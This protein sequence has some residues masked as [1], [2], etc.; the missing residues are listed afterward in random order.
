MIVEGELDHI[1]EQSFYMAGQIENVL[2]R[3]EEQKKVG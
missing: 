3:Y 1:P 2:E